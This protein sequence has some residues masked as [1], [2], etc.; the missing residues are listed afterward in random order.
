MTF[1]G[2]AVP[3]LNI[4]LTLICRDYLST[5]LSPASPMPVIGGDNNPQCQIPAVHSRTSNFILVLMLIAG[6][7]GAFTCSPLGALSDRIGRRKVLAFNSFGLFVG[8]V[9]TVAVVRWPEM[10]G[11]E[12]LLVGGIVDGLCGSFMLGM[13]LSYSYATDSTVPR[14][15]A[16]AF[17][18]FQGCLYLGIAV[19]PVLGGLLV[20]WTGDILSVFYAALV[21]GH[22]VECGV[23]RGRAGWLTAP[24]HA[25]VVYVVHAL[26]PP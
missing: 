21:S 1:G 12:F 8:E 19:G 16:T 25:C 11:I 24:G 10:F 6:I 5:S 9:C 13:A 2:T 3:K 26:H 15:R 17:G 18:A 22:R 23:S 4:I 7:L 14:H 20:E